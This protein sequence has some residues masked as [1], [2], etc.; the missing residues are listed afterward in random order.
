MV[1]SP[2]LRFLA[3]RAPTGSSRQIW[4]FIGLF[5]NLQRSQDPLSLYWGLG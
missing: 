3:L 5:P 2:T 4:Y 1:L